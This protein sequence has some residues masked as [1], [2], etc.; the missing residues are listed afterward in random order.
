MFFRF[1]A[2]EAPLFYTFTDPDTGR[3][4]TDSSISSLATSIIS[5]REQNTLPAI[6]KLKT[7]IENCTCALPENMHKCQENKEISRSF[8]EYIK[9]GIMLLN[10]KMKKQFASQE[11]AEARAAQ[12]LTCPNNSF[13]DKGPFLKWSDE[14]AIKQVGERRTSIHNLLGNCA[15]CSCPLRSKVFTADPLP[16][17]SDDQVVELNK[18]DCWQLKLSNQEK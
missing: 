12:C 1:K 13:P 7:V 10:N 3:V 8:S 11:V 4:F 9:G 2:F 15:V 5:Y 6:D 18:V 17:F 16:P 14:I